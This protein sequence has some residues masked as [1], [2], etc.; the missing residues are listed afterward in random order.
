MR[1]FLKIFAVLIF[2]FL[3]FAGAYLL[4]HNQGV[5]KASAE[6]AIPASNQELNQAAVSKPE[7]IWKETPEETKTPVIVKLNV[8]FT[9]QAPGKNWNYPWEDFCEEAVMLMLAQYYRGV[10]LSDIPAKGAS[11]AMLEMMNYEK[12]TFGYHKNIG[13]K[14]ITQTLNNLYGLNTATTTEATI[15]QIKEEI[16]KY[17]PVILPVS[18]KLLKNPHFQ[19]GGPLFHTV[20][21]TGYDESD[22]TF[23]VHEPGTRFGKYYKYGQELLFNAIY[24]WNQEKQKLLEKKVMVVVE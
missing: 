21:V 11:Q 5:F 24:D 9:T 17:R 19:R 20:L 16:L 2:E 14:E 10:P 18:G 4:W 8:P 23:I 22:S 15:E 3:L 13:S 7:I 6:N 12:K 1:F